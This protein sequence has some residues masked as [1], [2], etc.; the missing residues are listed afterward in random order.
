CRNLLIYI[1]PVVQR[2]L[3]SLFA[4]A[5][6]SAGYLFLGKS[7]GIASQSPYFTSASAKWRIYRRSTVSPPGIP[8]FSY[9]RGGRVWGIDT[10]PKPAAGTY[11]KF[12][13]LSQ[14]A[15]LKHFN[16]SV[17]LVDEHG[18]ILYFFGPT[19]KYLEHPTGEAHTNLLS[20]VDT[21]LAAKLRIA[22]RRGIEENQPIDLGRVEVLR[23]EIR[24]PVKI[25]VTPVPV[26]AK[27]E[28][29]SSVVFEDAP[30]EQS[31]TLSRSAAQSGEDDSLVAQ[32]ES[33]LKSLKAEFQS[34]INEYETSA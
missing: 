3:I 9:A 16:A 23:G 17:V 33:E 31:S 1:E 13:E 7:D 10:L 19:S 14:E 25:T 29:L 18:T 4:F 30:E 2:R 6:T 27:G 15:L 20:M 28:H 5:L 21:R 12:S 22:L 11:G 32:L 26:R 24:F 8:E 34:T